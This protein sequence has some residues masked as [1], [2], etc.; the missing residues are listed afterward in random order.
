[1]TANIKSTEEPVSRFWSK[2]NLMA[3]ITALFRN[4]MPDNAA[5][6]KALESIQR[7]VP[8][9]SSVLYLHNP[10]DNQMI[11]VTAFG[12]EIELTSITR[13]TG[14]KDYHKWM[15]SLRKP[16]L[17]DCGIDDDQHTRDSDNSLLIV[18]LI[19]EERLIGTVVF[20]DGVENSFR[21]KDVKLLTIIG[22]QIASFI[23]R[24]RAHR[25]VEEKNRTL[26]ET[27]KKLRQAQK[28][29]ID[30]EKLKAVRELAASINHEINNPLSVITGNVEYLLYINKN[31]E[32][33]VHER[34]NIIY[35][36][37]TRI[38]EI[39]RRLLEI[40]D[41]VTQDYLE[42]DKLTMLDLKK[43]SMGE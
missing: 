13:Q 43:S 40:Q 22:D 23:E 15:I 9:E 42:D 29:L 14:E 41:L 26:E 20:F 34:L 8:F 18:P 12:G 38:A 36:E 33:N 6:Q 37:A 32:K 35:G 31:L 10:D 7:V 1:L 19:I 30:T 28:E 25:E 16:T 21:D 4:S 11:E 17:I 24:S 3:E 2:M 27:Q 5:Y 39:N